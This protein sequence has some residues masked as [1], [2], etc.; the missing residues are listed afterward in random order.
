MD[1]PDSPGIRLRIELIAERADGAEIWRYLLAGEES[2]SA[3]EVRE[4]VERMNVLLRRGL[5]EARQSLGEALR[6]SS[7]A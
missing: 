7:P 1:T 2:V 4:I 5:D 3:T 6:R